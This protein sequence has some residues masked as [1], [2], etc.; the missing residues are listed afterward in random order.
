MNRRSDW[1]KLGRSHDRTLGAAVQA[2]YD[3]GAVQPANFRVPGTGGGLGAASPNSDART[4][5]VEHILEP[6]PNAVIVGD[7]RIGF[8]LHVSKE[9]ANHGAPPFACGRTLCHE[10]N[11]CQFITLPPAKGKSLTA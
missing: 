5:S 9:Y 8:Q 7:D 10:P 4:V 1:G 3:I 11:I 6:N 2:P